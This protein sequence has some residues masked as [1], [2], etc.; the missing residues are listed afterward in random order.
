MLSATRHN[1]TAAEY[2]ALPAI[3]RSDLELAREYLFA[4]VQTV[5]LKESPHD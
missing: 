4:R 5:S 3:S 2:F 1:M